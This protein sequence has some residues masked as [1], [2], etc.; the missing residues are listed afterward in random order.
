[1]SILGISALHHDSAVCLINK[2]QIVFAS[3]EERFSRIKNDSKWPIN[4]IKY[5]LDTYGQP[6]DIVFYDKLTFIKR[7]EIK[8]LIKTS[9]LSTKNIWFIEHHNS[10]AYSAIYTAPWS[11]YEP[12][13]VMVVD[14]I[15]GKKATSLGYW[16]GKTL[17]WIKTF[18]YPNSLG[19]FYSS[20]TRLIG[21]NS[22][23]DESKTMSAAAFGEPKWQEYMERYLIN[24]ENN[25]YTCLEDFE[26]GLGFGVL[27]FDI[28]SSAQK[29]L[30]KIL[31]NL[32]TWLAKE[33]KLTKL[34]YSGGV[35]LNCVA[36][37]RIIEKTPFKQIWV[38]PAAGDAGGA[39][40]GAI[41]FV[42]ADWKDAYLGYDA[43]NELDPNEVA[44]KIIGGEIV[45]VIRGRAEWGPR[46]LGNRSFLALPSK[47]NSMRLHDIKGRTKDRWRPWAPICLKS[48]AN[49]YF[50]IIQPSYEMMFVAY[51]KSKKW[52][53][54]PDNTA[55]LQVVDNSNNKWLTQVLK[56]TTE[57][58]HPVLIN[59]SL[60]VKGKPIVNTYDN[61]KKEIMGELQK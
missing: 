4:S 45:P 60:N 3:G 32:A 30:E 47:I 59:T 38:P 29:V 55:R 40:G 6:S 58:G 15:G 36:N 28:A 2:E 53:W 10:H 31:I 56:K 42:H 8:N 33:I 46:A 49:N 21:F 48:I 41:K 18:L 1:M 51:S 50:N 7:R 54:Y 5:I 34:V 37:T 13:G 12:C 14:T 26:R 19:L 44:N 57:N 25:N 20:I 52:Y 24:I 11:H 23:I 61:L 43:G 35:A 9:G 16:D 27:D 39:L 22:N 17:Y